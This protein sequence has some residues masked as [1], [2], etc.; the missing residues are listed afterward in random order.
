[1]RKDHLRSPCPSFDA[2][3]RSTNTPLLV[4][5]LHTYIQLAHQT[6]QRQLVS[7]HSIQTHHFC[8]QKS[9]VMV[10]NTF[11]LKLPNASEVQKPV[12]LLSTFFFLVFSSKF[13]SGPKNQN[14][15]KSHLQTAFL[16]LTTFS[17]TFL[18]FI[19]RDNICFHSLPSCLL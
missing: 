19:I 9:N 13:S 8:L 15:N 10:A 18:L 4:C 12:D 17:I 2:L 3:I 5:A 14:H 7:Q 6:S 16:S 1:M 11:S